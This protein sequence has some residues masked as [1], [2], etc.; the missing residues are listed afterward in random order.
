MTSKTMRELVKN[1]LSSKELAKQYLTNP[2]KKDIDREIDELTIKAT[3]I[4]IQKLKAKGYLED[5]EPTE[6]EFGELLKEAINECFNGEARNHS[7]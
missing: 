7:K 4:F 5:K 1:T 6:E 2:N 3:D